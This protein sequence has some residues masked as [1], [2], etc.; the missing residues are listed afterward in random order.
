LAQEENEQNQTDLQ[1]ESISPPYSPDEILGTSHMN[2]IH[3]RQLQNAESMAKK[4]NLKNNLY[5]LQ[6]HQKIKTFAS[7]ELGMQ[8]LFLK[9]IKHLQKKETPL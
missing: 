2:Q 7:N 4:G 8:P 3:K 9:N 1:I 6:N 5:A